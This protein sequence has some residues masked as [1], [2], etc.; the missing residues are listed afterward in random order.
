MKTILAFAVFLLSLGQC[1]ADPAAQDPWKS[2][3]GRY[4]TKYDKFKDRT[5]IQPKS[6]RNGAQIKSKGGDEVI[7]W[8]TASYPGQTYDPKK[9]VTLS[10]ILFRLDVSNKSQSTGKGR[11]PDCHGLILLLDGEKMDF[12]DMTYESKLSHDGFTGYDYNDQTMT[13]P[14]TMKQLKKLVAATK[15]EGQLCDTELE[16]RKDEFCVMNLI[17]DDLK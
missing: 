17:L 7:L 3:R 11:Y 1:L 8:I 2:C 12:G 9:P 13:A 6:L 14:L 10:L 4:E 15:I 5:T 16:F